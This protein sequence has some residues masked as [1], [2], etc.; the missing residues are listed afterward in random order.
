MNTE[1]PENDV[2]RYYENVG[3]S[4]E[5]ADA[6]LSMRGVVISARRWKTTAIAASVGL[7]IL[8]GVSASLYTTLDKTQTELAQVLESQRNQISVP[9]SPVLVAESNDQDLVT[10]EESYTGPF[11]LVSLTSH[12]QRCPQCGPA[13]ELFAD[14]SQEFEDQSVEF[15][16]VHLNDPTSVAQSRQMLVDLGLGDLFERRQET[17]YLLLTTLDGQVVDKVDPMLG[18]DAARETITQRLRM[19]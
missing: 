6:I 5:R 17:G 8:A 18:P 15:V 1:S 13:M 19:N 16:E 4:E 10:D 7:A 12:G 2:K 14:L 11:R 3:L 9:S